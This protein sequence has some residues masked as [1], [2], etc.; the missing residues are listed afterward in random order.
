MRPVKPPPFDYLAPSSLDEALAFR[1]EHGGDGTVLAGGQ[2]LMPLLNLRM[3]YP[4]TVIDLGHVEELAG[5]HSVDGGVAIRAMTRQ[6]DAER[7]DLALERCPLLVQ[8]LRHVGHV[9]IRNRGTVGGSLAH[10]DPAAELPAVA[11]ALGAQLVA[12][13]VRGERTIAADDFFLGFLTTALEPDELLVEVRF[14]SVGGAGRVGSSFLEIARR[15][16]DF[17]LVGALRSP[18]SRSRSIDSP[19]MKISRLAPRR[20]RSYPA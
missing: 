14:P 4:A 15:H 19:R 17:A 5:I 16:G 2:S 1:A 3:A 6:R 13:S 9:T 10:A 11:L 20:C 18:P 8:A 7:S 12:R